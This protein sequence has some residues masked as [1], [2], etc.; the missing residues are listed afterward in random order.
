M[1]L[2]NNSIFSLPGGTLLLALLIK[3]LPFNIL[4]SNF[5]KIIDEEDLLSC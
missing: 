3:T 2:R 4:P 1:L 5:Q